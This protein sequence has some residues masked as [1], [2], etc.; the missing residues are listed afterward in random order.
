[1]KK[2]VLIPTLVLGTL[3]TGSLAF[4][5]PYGFGGCGGDGSGRGTGPMN[6]EQHEDRMDHRLEMMTTVLDLT[7][8]QQAKVEALFNQQWQNHQQQR[9]QMQAARDAMR[10]ARF[11]DT[12]D[13]ADFRAKSAKQA[14][15]KTEMM[16]DRAKLQQQLYAIL[17]PE[18]Q[19]KAKTLGGLMG[20]HENGRHGGRGF[21]F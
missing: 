6:Y 12:F 7:D 17:T 8:D 4:A 3:L 9:E 20:G 5:G 19:A 13:E 2:R 11:A 15:L 14:E 10:E 1:M 21:R 16:V 18:Q